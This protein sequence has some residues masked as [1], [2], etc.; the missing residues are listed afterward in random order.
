MN[1]A[2]QFEYNKRFF[3]KKYFFDREG[4]RCG[5]DVFE[6]DSKRIPVLILLS[7]FK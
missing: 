2:H 7:H 1:N 3:N 5:N 4:V 6:K